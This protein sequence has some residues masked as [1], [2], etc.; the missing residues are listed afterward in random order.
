MLV[1]LPKLNLKLTAARRCACWF[2]CCM[3]EFLG[4]RYVDTVDFDYSMW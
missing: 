4:E 3:P 1:S 2:W